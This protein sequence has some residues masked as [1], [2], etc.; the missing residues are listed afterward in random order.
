QKYFWNLHRGNKKELCGKEHT[1]VKFREL[2]SKKFAVHK[3][4]AFYAER[5]R[6]SPKYLSEVLVEHTGLSAKKWIEFH[7]MQEAKYLLSFR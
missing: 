7:I 1:V 2:V 5:L 3:D 4:V 6:L